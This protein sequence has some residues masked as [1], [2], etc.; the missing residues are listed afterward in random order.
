MGTALKKQTNKKKEKE[1]HDCLHSKIPCSIEVFKS[2]IAVAAS[3]SDSEKR[4]VIILIL[5][6][7]ERLL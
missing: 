7:K 1:K 6:T 4:R 2:I 5:F 3:I